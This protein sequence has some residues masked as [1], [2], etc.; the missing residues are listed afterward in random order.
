MRIFLTGA[1]GYIG[2]ALAPALRGR[3]HDVGALVRP[4]SDSHQLRDAGVVI[5]AGD[6]AS[7]LTLGDTLAGYEVFIHAAQSNSP[8]DAEL[9][10]GSIAAYAAQKGFLIYTSGV[11]VLGNTVGVADESTPVNPL[12]MVTWRAGIER[13]A[14]SAGG[15]VIR[16]G[17]VYGGKQSLLAGWFAAAAKNEPLRIVGDGENYWALVDLHDLVDLYLRTVEQR[18]AGI[19]HA[20]DDTHATLNACAAAIAPKAALEHV[21]A[22]AARQSMGAFVDALTI[23]QHVSSAATRQRLGWAPKRDFIGSVKEQWSEWRD[24]LQKTQ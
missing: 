4:E 15:A 14:L 6:M 24:A 12:P 16:P 11:W 1:T 18:V 20:V 8:A 21:P 19:F 17:C 3:G 7:L 23:D 10:G 9:I 2:S 5:V 13:Q 22:G